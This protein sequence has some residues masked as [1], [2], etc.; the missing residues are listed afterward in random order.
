MWLTWIEEFTKPSRMI[1]FLLISLA[2]YSWLFLQFPRVLVAQ[3]QWQNSGPVE[4]HHCDKYP[5]KGAKIT[6][7]NNSG[8]IANFHASPTFHLNKNLTCFDQ[9]TNPKVFRRGRFWVFQNYIRAH[10]R[11]HCNE[12]ITYTTHADPTFFDNLQPL[13]ERWRGPVSL[14]V[15]APGTDFHKAVKAILYHRECSKANLVKNFVTFHMFFD[16]IFLTS[17]KEKIIQPQDIMNS[18]VQCDNFT[19]NQILPVKEK[20]FKNIYKLKYPVNLA[21]N[22][23]RE[24]A[25][26]FFVF[27]CDI[28]L[29]PSP[30]LIPNF[31]SMIRRNASIFSRSARKVFPVSVFE[32]HSGQIMPKT[33]QELLKLHSKNKVQL[34]H[35]EICIACHKIPKWSQ[36]MNDTKS[37]K[38]YLNL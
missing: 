30:G 14:S 18:V 22:L 25:N 36:W 15:Y 33:K 31:L 29:Y 11:F 2:V 26:S 20:L 35:S 24:S 27:P 12:T 9:D 1:L 4:L 17:I 7:N 8:T 5:S 37:G 21:R 34:F 13:L 38:C 3:Y 10:Q 32:I 19:A 23:A 28:E 6:V 16:D